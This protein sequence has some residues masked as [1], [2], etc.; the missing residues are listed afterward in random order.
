VDRSDEPDLAATSG[1]TR[2]VGEHVLERLSDVLRELGFG[3]ERQA[4]LLSHGVALP[5][6]ML[7]TVGRRDDA[8]LAILL[9]LFLKGQALAQEEVERALEPQLIADL[10][11]AGL[12]EVDDGAHLRSC[13][14]LDSFEGLIVASDPPGDGRRPGMVQGVTGAARMLAGLTIRR[15]IARALDLGTGSGIQALLSARHA[16]RVIGVDINPQ[17]L[18]LARITQRINGVGNVTWKEGDWFHPVR[19]ERFGLVVVNPPYV[20]SPDNAFIYRDSP[21]GADRLCRELVSGS[22]VH[23]TEGG[24]STVACH[25]VHGGDAWDEPLREWVDDLGCDVV[26]LH[27]TSDDPFDYATGWN[28]ELAA[29]DPQGFGETVKR[30]VRHLESIGATRIASGAIIL[31]RRSGGSNWVRGFDLDRG[32][33][34]AGGD[35]LERI[36]ISSDFLASHSGPGQLPALLSKA[37]R[38]VEPHRLDQTVLFEDG[39]YPTGSA[40]M[41]QRSSAGLNGRVDP[42]VLPVLLGCDGKRVLGQVIEGTLVPNELDRAEFHGLCLETVRDLIA[43]GFLVGDALQAP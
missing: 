19:G 39:R 30:W 33:T 9:E 15:Q 31:R 16:Q 43:R 20:L 2:G 11:D 26:L 23:L 34:G 13:M 5:A 1:D 24:F 17:A 28:I 36:F 41:S 10:L 40:I 22:A 32:P 37:W 7:E 38:L 3:G 35:Q 12:M 8:R 4:S 27:Q 25:W 29:D 42:R 21:T 14:R 18:H 6:E